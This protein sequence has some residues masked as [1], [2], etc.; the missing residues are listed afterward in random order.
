MQKGN[1]VFIK[2]G[3][4]SRVSLSGIPALR[5]AEEP[6]IS[7]SSDYTKQATIGQVKPDVTKGVI[8]AGRSRGS[9]PLKKAQGRDPEQ[10]LFR[11]LPIPMSGVGEARMRGLSRGF[12]LIELLVVV[13]IIGILAAVALPQYQKAV[14][15]SRV[16]EA[17]VL[18]KTIGNAS[19]MWCLNHNCC[20]E[21]VEIDKFDIAVP[22]ET[23]NWEIQIDECYGGGYN[24]E[25]IPMFET[26][27][28]IQYADK[29]YDPVHP[30]LAGHFICVVDENKADKICAS[31]GTEIDE[32]LYNID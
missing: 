2:K 21:S 12:T 22:V 8:P 25:A 11:I 9:M 29:N 27:Y 30:N 13:L 31:L 20:K 23:K 26:G 24:F 32:Y 6:L 28:R 10:Q 3:C 15:K 19:E 1:A 5:H 16:A 4:H 18:L 7:I 17:K 14:R